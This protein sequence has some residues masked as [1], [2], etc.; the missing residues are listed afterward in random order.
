MMSARE[1]VAAEAATHLGEIHWGLYS[2]LQTH[3]GLIYTV[4][5]HK[6]EISAAPTPARPHA[7]VRVWGSTNAGGDSNQFCRHHLYAV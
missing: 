7:C 2:P 5:G 6:V 1:E 3:A 4:S